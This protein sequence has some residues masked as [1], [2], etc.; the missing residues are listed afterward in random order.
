MPP[1][2][3][4]LTVLPVL[5]ACCLLACGTDLPEADSPGARQYVRFCD[6]QQCHTAMAPQRGGARYWR[7]QTDR[8]LELMRQQGVPT[9]AA[10]E[11]RLIRA[12]LGRHAYGSAN[13]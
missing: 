10:E 2:P 3:T 12:Y 1:R 5:L 7:E 9:P 13:P 6:R 4:T 11:E 8:M